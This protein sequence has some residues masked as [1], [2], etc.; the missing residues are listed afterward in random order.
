MASL[1]VVAGIGT[2]LAVSAATGGSGNPGSVAPHGRGFEAFSSWVSTV[3][4]DGVTHHQPPHFDDLAVR[5]SILFPAGTGYR[6]AMEALYAARQQGVDLPIG[7]EIAPP[8][9]KGKVV[10]VQNGRLM[11]DSAAPLGFDPNTGA[12]R[13]PEFTLPGS[14]TEADLTA[15][16]V[17]QRERGLPLPR[18]ATL[19]VPDLPRCQVGLPG[20]R[21]GTPG[22]CPSGGTISS[23]DIDAA[24]AG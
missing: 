21:G 23:A 15:R 19:L 17:E 4:P 3:G 16:F 1:L 22:V 6:A 7:A 11:V 18:G 5:A 24:I 9:S 2:I 20:D 12:V 14:L 13:S 8:L 10:V